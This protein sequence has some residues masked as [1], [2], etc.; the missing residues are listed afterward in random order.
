MDLG[1]KNNV[2][3]FYVKRTLWVSNPGHYVVDNTLS[4]SSRVYL[5]ILFNFILDL[6]D[7]QGF[8]MVKEGVPLSARSGS[9]QARQI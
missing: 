6:S 1:K 8:L 4:K 9:N 3:I 5:H 2:T 7:N